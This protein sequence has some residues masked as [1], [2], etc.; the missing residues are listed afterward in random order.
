MTKNDTATEEVE[1][2]LLKLAEE[3]LHHAKIIIV[4]TLLAA[5]IA[6]GVT[7]YLVTPLYTS[8][9]LMYVNNSSF[10][11]GS[12]SFSISSAE[13]TAAK[14]LV[15]TYSVILKS[16]N[17][18][19]DVIRQENL[20]YTYEQLYEMVSSS[21]V[22]A[23]EIFEINVTSPSPAEAE[24]LANVLAS[25]LPGKIAAI[26]EG[27]DV[28]IVDYAVIPSSRTS[29]SYTTNTAVGALAGFL[30]ICVIVVLRYLFDESIRSED[31]LSQAYPN[32]PLLAVVPDMMHPGK[33]GDYGS[34]YGGGRSSGVSERAERRSQSAPSRAA[35]PAR[36][37]GSEN[38]PAAERR[39]PAAGSQSS[40]TARSAQPSAA[41]R[42]PRAGK[43]E[44]AGTARKGERD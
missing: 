5:V 15:D 43:A 27:S 14:S 44:S 40:G 17:T 22:N 12:T 3:L 38:A 18:L 42:Q 1:I 20:P 7:Y 41:P 6:F 13:L 16:R 23:T 34:Y 2:D 26:V 10:T 9:A 39:R 24:H 21:A 35:R 8:T 28:R 4:V 29:P 25:V 19:E 36:P 32:I 37:S 30:L 31:Y 33:G 11:V